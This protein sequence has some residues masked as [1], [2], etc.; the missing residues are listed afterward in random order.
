MAKC[1]ESEYI[2]S[3]TDDNDP[4]LFIGN[5]I[6]NHANGDTH[7]KEEVNDTLKVLDIQLMYI[8]ML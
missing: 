7:T 8:Y 1:Y 2:F 3:Q 6:I 4:L 5:Y